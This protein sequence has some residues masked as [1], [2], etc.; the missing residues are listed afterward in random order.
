MGLRKL[1]AGIAAAATLLGGAML[2]T[3]SAY[4]EDNG[5]TQTITI[6]NGQQGHTYKAYKVADFSNVQ[7]SEDGETITSMDIDTVDNTELVTA[8]KQAIAKVGKDLPTE[9]ENNPM[10]FVAT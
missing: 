3:A 2:G 5:A 10:A 4:A 6:M 7:F 1:M 9:Y 8:L